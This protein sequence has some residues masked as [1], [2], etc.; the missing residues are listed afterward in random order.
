M[1]RRPQHLHTTRQ[2]KLRQQLSHKKCDVA[3]QLNRQEIFFSLRDFFVD[4]GG[5]T[6]QALAKSA[7]FLER[8]LMDRVVI[9]IV[10]SSV[11][12]ATPSTKAHFPAFAHSHSIKQCC[13]RKTDGACLFVL[14]DVKSIPPNTEFH[15]IWL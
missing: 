8:V 7:L 13:V 15:A 6:A 2:I 12:N 4:Q 5:A 3:H 14:K 9:V 1:E 11:C 10:K